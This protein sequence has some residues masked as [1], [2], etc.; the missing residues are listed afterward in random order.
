MILEHSE[1]IRSIVIHRC[2]SLLPMETPTG[3]SFRK[4]HDALVV[5]EKWQLALEVSH[6]CGFATTGVMAAW[7]IACLKAGCFETGNL[8]NLCLC[9]S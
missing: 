5:A 9:L 3:F 1:I 8:E 7:G 4:L 2:E 6:K